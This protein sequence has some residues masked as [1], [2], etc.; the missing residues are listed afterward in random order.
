MAVLTDEQRVRSRVAHGLTHLTRE[1]LVEVLRRVS[2]GHV[3]DVDPPAVETVRARD[4]LADN[5][6]GVLEDSM[7]EHFAV[8][9]ELGQRL[10]AKP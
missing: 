8:V 4:P 9:V 10:H 7:A 5:T 6:I 3:G 2:T 1:L